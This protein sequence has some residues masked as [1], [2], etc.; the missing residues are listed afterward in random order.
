MPGRVVLI[1][2]SERADAVADAL[3][4]WLLASS[5]NYGSGEA[6]NELTIRRSAVS[7]VLNQLEEN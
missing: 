6:D 5:S 7:K 1:I 3:S 4:Y 2:G